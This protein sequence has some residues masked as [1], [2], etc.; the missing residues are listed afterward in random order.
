[1]SDLL[2]GCEILRLGGGRR[3]SNNFQEWPAKTIL[4]SGPQ[5]HPDYLTTPSY[6]RSQLSVGLTAAQ[7]F[8]EAFYRSHRRS[9]PRSTSVHL[10]D[11]YKDLWMSRRTVVQ[12]VK[13]DIW[14]VTTECP[15][16]APPIARPACRHLSLVRFV[17]NT[18]GYNTLRTFRL[19]YENPPSTDIQ[20]PTP[21][22]LFS[23]ENGGR[24]RALACTRLLTQ[25]PPRTPSPLISGGRPHRIASVKKR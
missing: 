6:S 24:L 3:T 5:P 19:D 4:E 12:D 13:R 18:H 1:M 2:P 22:C 11:T 14:V 15:H 21:R 10:K 9:H 7:P 20:S 25:C 8:R 17:A 16:A 23:P